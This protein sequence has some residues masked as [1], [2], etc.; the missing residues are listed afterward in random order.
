[1]AG[2]RHTPRNLPESSAAAVC[3]GCLRLRRIDHEQPD[4]PPGMP[5]DGRRH[6]FGIAGHARDQRRAG[7]AGPIEL[8]DPAVGERFSRPGRFPPELRQRGFVWRA[9]VGILQLPAERGE[10]AVLRRNDNGRRS[11]LR[12]MAQDLGSRLRPKP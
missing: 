12:S 3:V 11:S 5:R 9:L 8:G 7:D 2:N 4:Q 6:R 10:E 1:M